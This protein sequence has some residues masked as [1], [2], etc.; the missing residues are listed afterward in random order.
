MYYLVKE[1]VYCPL[2]DQEL[3]KLLGKQEEIKNFKILKM[4]FFKHLQDFHLLVLSLKNDIV[5]FEIYKLK[6]TKTK[7]FGKLIQ[8]SELKISQK[9]PQEAQNLALG[10]E[11]SFDTVYK[12]F[13]G[14]ENQ[15]DDG[16]I[17]GENTVMY[18]VKLQSGVNLIKYF[19]FQL[20]LKGGKVRLLAV[21]EEDECLELVQ[22]RIGREKTNKNDGCQKSIEVKSGQRVC[23][24]RF[25]VLSGDLVLREK[26][27]LTEFK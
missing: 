1:D 4:Q 2:Q 10:Y 13:F 23:E 18:V 9:L 25:K 7:S 8:D 26:V 16:E 6:L 21:V 20:D 27:I 17:N 14:D 22:V 15:T 12:C 24:L 3:E 11:L 5:Y 19:G